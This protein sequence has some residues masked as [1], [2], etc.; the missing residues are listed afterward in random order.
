MPSKCQFW[1]TDAD[2]DRV[3]HDSSCVEHDVEDAS[4]MLQ[5]DLFADDSNASTKSGATA[6]GNSEPVTEK[7]SDVPDSS[8]GSERKASFNK[9]CSYLQ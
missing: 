7:H 6:D 8:S 4:C 3:V 9:E 1:Q 2:E 5:A